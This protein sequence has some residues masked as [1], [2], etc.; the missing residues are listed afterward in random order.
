MY[1]ITHDGQQSRIAPPSFRGI[2]QKQRSPIGSLQTTQFCGPPP[3]VCGA[4]ASVSA[5]NFIIVILMS[6]AGPGPFGPL[7]IRWFGDVYVQVVDA[8]RAHIAH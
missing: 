2:L 4:R 8:R 1:W 5:V 6:V 7:K 3:L